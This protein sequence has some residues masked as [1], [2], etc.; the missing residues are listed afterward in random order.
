MPLL[1]TARFL[2][3]LLGMFAGAAL[4]YSAGRMILPPGGES[5]RTEPR[6]DD[7]AAAFAIPEDFAGEISLASIGEA[8]PEAE[9]AADNA[10]YPEKKLSLGQIHE[11][12]RS[13]DDQAP[14][15]ETDKKERRLVEAW[16]E[17]D[18]EGA[19]AYAAEIFTLG[20]SE[21]LLKQA[22]KAFAEKNP[23]AAADWASSLASPLARDLAVRE[24]FETWAGRD[25]RTAAA[26]IPF[27]PAGS[28]QAI[29]AA[30][31][32]KKFSLADPD[33]AIAWMGSLDGAV[34]N[35]A[36]KSILLA[37]WNKSG[38][39]NPAPALA[40]T[41]SQNLPSLRDQGLR[42]VASEWVRRDP[43]AA[44]LAAQ[45]ISDTQSRKVFLETAL[46]NYAKTNPE[47]AAAWLAGPQGIQYAPAF[48]GRIASGWAAYEPAAAGAWASSITDQA[49]RNRAVDAVS[50][51]WSASSPA[52]ASA[53]ISG[54]PDAG[55]RDTATAAFS[56][57]LAKTD[58]PAAAQW[59][60]S[61][62]NQGMRSRAITEVVKTWKKIDLSAAVAFVQTS[63]A[64]TAGQRRKLLQ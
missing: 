14:G 54:L 12:L 1:L 56:S 15:P 34:R 31:V 41:L 60:A 17:L 10:L 13:L 37:Q 2:P 3:L 47:A 27:L 61:I 6:I 55:A 33:G 16:S 39:A 35:A 4:G 50:R 21:K 48:S 7:A 45:Q 24:T 8:E 36:F 32:A 44:L 26:A 18:P 64:L 46:Q 28:A 42:I 62:A 49:S 5:A 43:A 57:T 29:A 51:T 40:W 30:A 20:G 25:A 38:A 63:P 58:P 22:A 9:A 19:A 52:A 23:E 53:W 59:A 11:A